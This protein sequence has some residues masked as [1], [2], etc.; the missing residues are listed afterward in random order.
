MSLPPSSVARMLACA[1]LC[2]AVISAQQVRVNAPLGALAARG[3]EQSV[4][5]PGKRVEMFENP[6]LDRYLERA[7]MFLDRDDYTS[8]VKV[9]QDV[10]EGRTV[11]VFATRDEGDDPNAEAIEPNKS[12]K[13]A[14]KP[15]KTL[16]PQTGRRSTSAG[17]KKGDER[18]ASSELDAR[19]AVFS[20]DGRIYRPV[21]RLCH[22]LLSRMPDVGIQIYRT[23][24]EFAADEMLTE[25]MASGSSTALEQ[26][27]NRYFVTLPAGRAMMLLADRLMHEGRYR[28]SVQVLRDL[29]DV[30]PEQ[31]RKALGIRDTWCHFK[32]ALCLRLAGENDAAQEVV[33]V[34]ADEYAEESLRIRG[35][36]ETI[37]DLPNSKLFARDTVA[38]EAIPDGNAGLQWL[39]PE[40]TDLVPLWQ[41]RFEN[42][43]PYKDPKPSK[44][45][46]NGMFFDGRNQSNS[47][48]FANRY[49]P[50]TR[51]LF[52]SQRDGDQTVPRA[53]FLEHYRLRLADTASG[54]L[55][56][57]GDGVDVPPLAREGH[58]RV[59]I[60]ACDY[61]LLRPVEDEERRF[62]IIG[63]ESNTTQ[64][65]ESLKASQLVAYDKVTGKRSWS[66]ENWQDGSN[67]L[68]QVTFLAAP[69]VFGE[70]LML[71]SMRK[72]AYTLECLDRRTGEPLWHTPLHA[73][74]SPFFK[75]P[76]CPVVVQ[77]GIAFV[78]T[79]AGCVAAV[80]A[81]AGDL[82]WIRRYE[83]HDSAHKT[84][85]KKKPRASSRRFNSYSNQF[86]QAVLDSFLPSDMI[87][88]DGLLIV[89]PCDSEVLLAIEAATGKSVW[90]LDGRTRY[91]PYGRVTEVVGHDDKQLFVMSD[92][93]LVSIELEGGLVRWM[94]KLPSWAGPKYSGRGR[95]LIVNGKVIVPNM[96]ELLVFDANNKAPMRRLHLPAFDESREPLSGSCHL[97][98]KGPW[99]AVGYQ[100]GVEVYSTAVALSQL[101]GNTGDPMRKASY[102]TKS[103]DPAQAEKVLAATVA[104]TL[105]V[106][107]RLRAAKQLL[108]L[109][110]GR[111]EGLARAGK[112][113]G[114]LKAMDAVRDL[115]ADRTV[116]LN[117]HLARI[118]ICKDAGDMRAHES[119][120]QSLY[121]YMEGRG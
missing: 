34:L 92:S 120:Q 119:E 97:F 6:N 90:M 77:G 57:Q 98:V 56:G 48:P 81:F 39:Q 108:A 59:R 113:P 105:D 117:W 72:N 82:R 109:V 103:G 74:G 99:L 43:T 83:R 28:A 96:R 94:Q 4:D 87:M 16:A 107:V 49:G 19:N 41:Y 44:R 85:R 118:E 10:I 95:G 22:E 11:E 26:V 66:S 88:H 53:V 30:Y 15:T 69:T 76:G 1:S 37:H 18:V 89:A 23:A 52:S 68:R 67:G 58:P 3:A 32:I 91:A 102:L 100:G 80:D 104:N 45:G 121:D 7:Q 114:A 42:E 47:M 29:L 31:N 13:T 111:A 2:A 70:R 75:A 38:I 54:L 14:P 9:L 101:A 12:P 21:R 27:A 112:L 106:T 84:F 61:A 51:V 64:S 65:K 79:N 33:T 73:G 71:P 78:A 63:H 50:G 115:L 62:I 35:Q 40:T 24:H 36:L 60:A 110:S 25:A 20:R 17:T 55:I 46:R 116:R 93:H 5:D 86:T 8:A